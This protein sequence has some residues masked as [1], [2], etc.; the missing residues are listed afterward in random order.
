MTI[1]QAVDTDL[2]DLFFLFVREYRETKAAE[3]GIMLKHSDILLKFILLIKQPEYGVLLVAD[4]G[5]KIAGYI[6]GPYHKGWDGN[7]DLVTWNGTGWYVKKE[8]RG[9]GIE[10]R[11]LQAAEES[12]IAAGVA[13][14]IMLTRESS[15][16]RA[17]NTTYVKQIKEG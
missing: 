13:S 9:Q 4:D 15:G 14:H 11:L 8:N 1:R 10:M 3:A 17:F 6:Y 16:Y 7:D 2:I 5:D 12:V